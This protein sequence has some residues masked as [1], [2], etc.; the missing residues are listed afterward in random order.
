MSIYKPLL[1]EL[2]DWTKFPQPVGL[3]VMNEGSGN[4]IYD[5]SGNGNA[6]TFI[7]AATVWTA[8]GTG[9]W[10]AGGTGPAVALP[11][12]FGTYIDIDP[13][14]TITEGAGSCTFSVYFNALAN[15]ST[16]LLLTTG[17]LSTRGIY[18]RYLTATPETQ[19][20]AYNDADSIVY[21]ASSAAN[22]GFT[23]GEWAQYTITWDSVSAH[24][25]KD[26]VL[27][28]SDTSA[29]NPPV[30]TI[31]EIQTRSIIG[32]NSADCLIEYIHIWDKKL[33]PPEIS[34]LYI[35]PFPWFVKEPAIKLWTP[36]EDG[37]IVVLR[38]RRE[39]A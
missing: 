28:L 4:K 37:G 36:P 9:P 1:G 16:P 30:S 18:C 7:G 29:I 15:G 17:G 10:T 20:L 32:S 35:D 8:G 26:G 2:P 21:N 25:Y 22:V 31:D 13:I 14:S 24:L 23:V 19:L 3:W 39:C 27:I 33:S 38:R 12:T 6:G 11:G 5:L 34:Q